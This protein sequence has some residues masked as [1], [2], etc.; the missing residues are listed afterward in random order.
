MTNARRVRRLL[1]VLV[2]FAFTVAATPALP[3]TPST[4]PGGFDLGRPEIRQFVADVSS[5]HGLAADEISALLAAGRFQ[6]RIIEAISRP[7]ERV[8]PWHE[9][10]ARFVTQRR[11]DEGV[12]FLAEHRSRLAAAEQSTGVDPHY[13]VAI[14]GV[15]T[16][17]GRNTG[18]WRV[19]DALMTLGFD[20]PPRATFFRGELEQFLLLVREERIDPRAALGSYAGAMGAPQFIPSS[21][22]RFAVDGSADGQ[23][24]LFGDWDDVIASVANYFREHGWQRGAPVLADAEAEPTRMATLDPRNLELDATAGSL[25]ASGVRVAAPVPDDTPAIL[26]PAELADGPSVRVGFG[27]FRVITRYN[28]SIRYAMAVHDLA[29]AIRV[30]AA[31]QLAAASRVEGIATTVGVP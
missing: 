15:E 13:I 11:I 21:Y 26:V 16:F 18:S 1:A 12:A 7:A 20:Y 8:V 30:R 24:N 4:E 14:I 22:R 6:P 29:E 19:L 10:R 3:A 2:P 9:Y 28:R 27:N 31:E 23:R 25:R 5:R 17:Y